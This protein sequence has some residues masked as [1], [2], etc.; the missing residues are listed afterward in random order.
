ME[1]ADKFD[2]PDTESC[3]VMV[4]LA[5]IAFDMLDVPVIVSFKITTFVTF[6]IPVIVSFTAV[7]SESVVL[8]D[9]FSVPPI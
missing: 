6:N 5:I 4:S 2:V 7:T 1:T 8:P 9:T 3:P